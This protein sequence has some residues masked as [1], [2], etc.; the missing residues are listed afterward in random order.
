MKISTTK[1][2]NENRT[3]VRWLVALGRWHQ[4]ARFDPTKI[5]TIDAA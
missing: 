4:V 5:E 3:V 1:K 2:K